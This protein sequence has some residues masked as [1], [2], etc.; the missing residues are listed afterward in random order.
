MS[1]KFFPLRARPHTCAHST[2]DCFHIQWMIPIPMKD[3]QGLPQAVPELG[4]YFLAKCQYSLYSLIYTSILY[5]F[6]IM[7][8]NAGVVMELDNT[9]EV[10]TG[11]FTQR[12][13]S[14][15]SRKDLK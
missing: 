9:T 6:V 11:T 12:N 7:S 13:R 1:N 14:P 8:F 3:S 5:G 15:G 10:N 2:G 4:M